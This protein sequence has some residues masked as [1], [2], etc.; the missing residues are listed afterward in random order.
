MT[1][2]FRAEEEI[3]SFGDAKVNKITLSTRL[4]VCHKIITRISQLKKKWKEIFMI[5]MIV[6]F[7]FFL[8]LFMLSTP[9]MWKMEEKLRCVFFTPPS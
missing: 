9:L 4:F 6:N 1:L 2:K 3:G 8:F 7:P 5:T